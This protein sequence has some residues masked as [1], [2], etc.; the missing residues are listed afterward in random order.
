MQQLAAAVDGV[1]QALAVGLGDV[2]RKRDAHHSAVF[3]DK[4]HVGL[5]VLGVDDPDD[6]LVGFHLKIGR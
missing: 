5:V 6:A 2:S 1:L 4:Q 3:K